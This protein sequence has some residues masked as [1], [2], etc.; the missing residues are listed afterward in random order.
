MWG[1]IGSEDQVRWNYGYT[2]GL[3]QGTNPVVVLF[4]EALLGGKE[5]WWNLNTWWLLGAD[6]SVNYSSKEGNLS[7]ALIWQK[8]SNNV[9]MPHHTKLIYINSVYSAKHRIPSYFDLSAQ[10]PVSFIPLLELHHHCAIHLFGAGILY[11]LPWH[12]LAFTRAIF[13]CIQILFSMAVFILLG[14]LLITQNKF[15]LLQY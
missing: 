3:C 5:I 6:L 7:P 1:R 13:S 12:G 9:E 14:V 8:C 10:M 11:V 2:M 15:H 4:E